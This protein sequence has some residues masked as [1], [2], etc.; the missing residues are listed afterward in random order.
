MG[1]EVNF[2]G[3]CSSLALHVCA[4]VMCKA[5]QLSLWVIGLACTPG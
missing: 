1:P 2:C 3:T 4:A 5:D